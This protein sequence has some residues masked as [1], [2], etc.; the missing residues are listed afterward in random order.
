[1]KEIQETHKKVL[2]LSEYPGAIVAEDDGV[3]IA[4]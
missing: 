1:M 4:I 2:Y 3:E